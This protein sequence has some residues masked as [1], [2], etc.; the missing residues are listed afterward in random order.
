[1]NDV[2][3][4]RSPFSSAPTLRFATLSDDDVARAGEHA[5]PPSQNDV[6]R[7]A[8]ALVDEGSRAWPS[9]VL[10]A[11]MLVS[12]VGPRLVAKGAK[13]SPELYLV[14]ACLAGDPFALAILDGQ[15]LAKVPAHVQKIVSARGGTA[16]ELVALV[17]EH[18][19]RAKG[20]RAPRLMAYSG[21]GLLAAWLRVVAVRFA[22]EGYRVAGKAPRS[23]AATEDHALVLQGAAFRRAIEV[24]REALPEDLRETL[25]L[26]YGEGL[27]GDRAAKVLGTSTATVTRRL[28]RALGA[29]LEAARDALVAEGVTGPALDRASRDVL[30]A[31][32]A[33][34]AERR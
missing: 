9:V 18:L 33:M 26:V 32:Q 24:A 4:E 30:S 14:A 15:Y 23:R 29:L 12:L 28:G 22:L 31:L 34:L 2:S 13:L 8:R 17:R 19:L 1:M 25:R 16:D 27:A 11:P 5:G 10:S 6:A 20:A 3:S 7:T 21:R